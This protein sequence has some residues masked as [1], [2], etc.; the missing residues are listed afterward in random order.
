MSSKTRPPKPVAKY[1]VRPPPILVPEYGVPVQRTQEPPK[2]FPVYGVVVPTQQPVVKYGGPY[3]PEEMPYI[4]IFTL[5][6]IDDEG[7]PGKIAVTECQDCKCITQSC[8]I[9]MTS[10]RPL[11]PR[12]KK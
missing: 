2:I 10:G 1:G 5:L 4:K 9:D 11:C 12:C 8:N 3:I 7:N 6:I